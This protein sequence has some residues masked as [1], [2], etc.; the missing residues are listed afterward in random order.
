M[1]LRW[2]FDATGDVMQLEVE[3]AV[4]CYCDNVIRQV[5]VAGGDVMQ[6]DVEMAVIRWW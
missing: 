3:I 2:Q 1:M 5:F 6:L 4:G